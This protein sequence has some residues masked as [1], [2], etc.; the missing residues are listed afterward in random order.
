MGR[1]SFSLY[2]EK[3]LLFPLD[4]KSH[5]RFRFLRFSILIIIIMIPLILSLLFADGMIDGITQKYILLQDGHIQIYNRAPLIENEEEIKLIDKRIQSIDYVVSGYGIMFQKE[6]NQEIYIKGV[7]DSYF[8]ELRRNE[9]T[10]IEEKSLDSSSSSLARIYISK[11]QQNNLGVSLGDNVAL[12]TIPENTVQRIRP[13]LATIVGIYESGYNKIDESLIFM[14]LSSALTL[15]GDSK[16]KSEVI[17]DFNATD[18]LGEIVDALN[19]YTNST[20][21]WATF[22]QFNTSIYRNFITSRQVI[23]LVFFIILLVAGVYIASIAHEIVEDSKQSIAMLKVLGA[24]NRQLI[25]SYFLT[26]LAVTS[27]SMI[28]GVA[29]GLLLS[30]RLTSIL[31]LI[32]QSSFIGLSYYLLDFSLSIPY[33]DIGLIMGALLLIASLFSL[34]TLRRII[35]ISPL[36]VLQQD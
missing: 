13:K 10:L 6:A 4:K 23:L 32:Q 27:L 33:Q 24:T 11:V 12:V 25:T 3:R 31:H 2:L 19:E 34:L 26:I 22:Q 9:F 20:N 1:F 21:R 36:E 14:N 35:N 7:E 29:L 5:Q 30:L 16:G 8:N 15:F 28:I 17:V 18:Q